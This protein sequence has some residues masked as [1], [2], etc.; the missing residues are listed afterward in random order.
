MALDSKRMAG[1]RIYSIP[2]APS[3]VEHKSLLLA[4]SL[5]ALVRFFVVHV[6]SV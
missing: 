4:K 1:I 5:D 3:A 6:F 2:P